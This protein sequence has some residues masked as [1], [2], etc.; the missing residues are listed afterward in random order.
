MGFLGTIVT[1]LARLIEVSR[2]KGPQISR[3]LVEEARLDAAAV[4]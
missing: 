2:S 3:A 1:A 4:L